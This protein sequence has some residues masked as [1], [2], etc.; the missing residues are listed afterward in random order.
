MIVKNQPVL[1]C[2]HVCVRVSFWW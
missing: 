2:V 1:V